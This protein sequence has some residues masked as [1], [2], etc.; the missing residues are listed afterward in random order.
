[1][2]LRFT[3]RKNMETA[4]NAGALKHVTYTFFGQQARKMVIVRISRYLQ[5][6]RDCWQ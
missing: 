5:R 1:M 4:L 2:E 6:K 3:I